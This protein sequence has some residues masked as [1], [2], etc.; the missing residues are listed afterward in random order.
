M[1]T[2]KGSHLL[3]TSHGCVLKANH[4]KSDMEMAK[5]KDNIQKTEHMST[6]YCK[7]AVTPV[8]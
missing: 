2:S 1:T 6:A 3:T 5:M 7:T 4:Y 8:R